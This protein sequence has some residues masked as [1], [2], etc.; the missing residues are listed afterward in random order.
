MFASNPYATGAL[1]V[2]P[3]TLFILENGEIYAGIIAVVAANLVI[4]LYICMVFNE[5]E[6]E[7]GV[8]AKK[9]L[10]SKN[11]S[12]SGDEPTMSKDENTKNNGLKKRK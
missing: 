12:D 11:E 2:I 4:L 10:E 1:L 7:F 5:D 8:K 9:R 3:K 6:V